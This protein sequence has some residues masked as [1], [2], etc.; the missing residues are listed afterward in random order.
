LQFSRSASS[1]GSYASAD[2][3]PLS[4]GQSSIIGGNGITG[5]KKPKPVPPKVFRCPVCNDLLNEKD[6]ARHIG[7]WVDKLD[8]DEIVKTGM[9]PGVR[10]PNHPLLQRFPGDNLSERVQCLVRNIKSLVRPGAYDAM[11]SEGSGRHIDVDQR[12]SFLL[13]RDG[14]RGN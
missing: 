2:C 10:D 8:K 11:T 12:I 1:A 7:T 6:F 14:A 3:S 4:S 9:C 13:S 5:T